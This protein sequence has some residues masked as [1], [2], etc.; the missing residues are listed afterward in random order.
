MEHP[1]HLL[2]SRRAFVVG[3]ALAL[4][5]AGASAQSSPRITVTKDPTCG[6]CSGWVDHLRASGFTVAVVESA[7]LARVKARLGIP[8]DLASCH[9]AEVGGYAVEGHVPAS[10]ITRL[11]KER[12]PAKGLAVPG[13]PIGSP[14][15]E[16]QGTPS[17]EYAVVLFGPSGRST[18]A[19]FKG[20][21]ELRA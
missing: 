4:S 17:E 12:P 9:T 10:A 5:P 3:A 13:M 19:R 21:A 11:L 16:M 20:A 15:M 18:Y 2:L 14:G 1:M 6:C 8:E 7:D